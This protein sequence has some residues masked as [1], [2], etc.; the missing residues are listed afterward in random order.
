VSADP[1]PAASAIALS[2][3][4]GMT[5]RRLR[6]LLRRHPPVEA[7][8]VVRGDLPDEVFTDLL[9]SSAGRARRPGHGDPATEWIRRWSDALDGEP[10]TAWWER[11]V[12]SG[13]GVTLH[14]DADYPVPLLDDPQAPA[15]LYHRGDLGALDGRRVAVVG[16]RSATAAGKRTATE[17]GH[18]LAERGVRVVS[19][20][21]RGIDGAVHQGALGARIGPPI[22]VVAS[23]LDVVYPREHGDLWQ[24]VAAAG[25]LLSERPPGAPPRAGAFPERNRILAALAELVVVVES[26]ATGGSLLT[27]REAHSRDIPVVAFP[28]SIASTASDGTNQLLRDGMA[29]VVLDPTDVLVALG[30]DTRRADRRRFDPRP[31]LEGPDRE[32]VELIGPDAV[33]LEE[34][35]LRSG[36]GLVD[37]AVRLGRLEAA[38]WVQRSGGWFENTVPPRV[39]PQPP[40]VTA[41]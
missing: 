37:V 35:V 18:G 32:L 38:G 1:P 24:R 27:V 23:G 12:A 8:A 10:V 16:T 41:P 20:L 11:F 4:E 36:A 7:V 13:I 30:L 14:G 9:R 33:T 39:S 19:G 31:A 17:L 25:L 21:A 15:V 26:R 22:A 29:A 34:L 2:G 3:L 6:V 28:G 5:P 40:P